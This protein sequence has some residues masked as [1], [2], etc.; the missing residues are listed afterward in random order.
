MGL[1]P[2]LENLHSK[3]FYTLVRSLSFWY[4]IRM[5]TVLFGGAF[6]PPHS[7][8]TRLCTAAVSELRADRLVLVPTYLPPHK[9]EGFLDFEVRK[10]LCEK[11]FASC[12]KEVIVDGI[13]FERKRCNYTYKILPILKEKYGDC[14]Y[15]IGG[16]SLQFLDTWKNTSEILDMCPIAAAERAGY[17]SVED[18]AARIKQKYGKGEII[19]INFKGKEVSSAAIKARLFLGMPVDELDFEIYDYIVKNNLFNK[20]KSSV[21]KIKS[22]QSDDLFDHTQNVV[23]RTVELNSEHNLK[24]DFVKCFTAALLHDNAK[25][26]KSLDGLNV[27]NDA[28]DTKVLHQFLGAE[29]AKRDFKIKDPEILS[30]IRCH[31]TAK[32]DMTTFEKLI[33]AADSTS[34]DRNYEP[35]PALRRAVDEDFEQG[36]LAVLSYTYNKLLA[37]KMP[38]YPLTVEAVKFYLGEDAVK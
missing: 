6:D 18:S 8:H 22:Y 33:Y 7:E 34:Y 9:S 2:D 38:I 13:E 37:D 17:D 28:V 35:I 1:L 12:A 24:Q 32:P 3:S 25:Q 21:D 10:N 30:A 4:N 31:T 26:R 15:L 20:F 27:P 11:A 23:L 14:V 29:K 36:F 19:S 16:D 5:L